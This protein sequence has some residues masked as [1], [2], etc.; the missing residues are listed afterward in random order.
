MAIGPLTTFLVSR[1]KKS[2]I[3]IPYT[4]RKRE[5]GQKKRREGGRL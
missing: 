4:Q 5:G 1:T 2:I 3:G